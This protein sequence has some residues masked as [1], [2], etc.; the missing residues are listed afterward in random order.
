VP[1]RDEITLR[2]MRFHTTVGVLPFEAEHAQP[3]EVDLTVWL[4]IAPT[5]EPRVVDYRDLYDMVSGVVGRGGLRYL[6]DAAERVVELAMAHP[7]VLGARAALRKPHVALPGPLA[8]AE[9]V[10]ER[11]SRG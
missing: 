2:G 10:I 7:R 1:T 3:L 5:D 8:H 9:V 6:E 4:G 11:G